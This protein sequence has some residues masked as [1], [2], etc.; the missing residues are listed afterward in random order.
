[1]SN[2]QTNTSEIGAAALLLCIFANMLILGEL[3]YS[4]NLLS[5]LKKPTTR[6]T[7]VTVSFGP[8]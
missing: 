7:G 5:D 2:I 8:I 3:I 6:C 4:L 1:M